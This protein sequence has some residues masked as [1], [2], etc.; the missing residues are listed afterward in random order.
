[1][2]I[3]SREIG[4]LF[5][6]IWHKILVVLSYCKLMEICD[7]IMVYLAIFVAQNRNTEGL[8]MKKFL[9]I[10]AI[11]SLSLVLFTF[12]SREQNELDDTDYNLDDTD[13]NSEITYGASY[14]ET[15]SEVEDA[16]ARNI[17]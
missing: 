8:F 15:E 14:D 5:L 11:I 13:Y 12:C 3:S 4:D 7:T 9:S 2:Q 1:M 17:F 10:L 6:A 16:F